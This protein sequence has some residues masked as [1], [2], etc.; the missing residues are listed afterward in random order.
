VPQIIST[1]VVKK[2]DPLK[3]KQ[4][5]VLFLC[6]R[7]VFGFTCPTGSIIGTCADKPAY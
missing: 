7:N 3:Q 1:K 5:S 2:S 6:I 4:F